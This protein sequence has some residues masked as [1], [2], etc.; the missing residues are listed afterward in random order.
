[1]STSEKQV[2]SITTLAETASDKHDS[3]RIVLVDDHQVVRQGV[4]AMLSIEK[5]MEIVGDYGSAEEAM[6]QIE[7]LSPDI[8]LLDFRM[9]GLNGIEACRLLKAKGLTCDV[10]ILTLY[11][12]HFAEA[13]R[14]GAKGYL[15]KDMKREELISTVRQVYHL[16]NSPEQD[17][18]SDSLDTIDL[19]I[20]SPVDTDQI[21]RFMGF[22]PVALQ[23]SIEQVIKLLDGSTAITMRFASSIKH[24]DVLDKLRKISDVKVVEKK[25]AAKPKFLW[26]FGGK[27]RSDISEKDQ[28]MITLGNNTDSEQ[29]N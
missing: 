3:I 10:V 7:E 8:V 14:A 25:L 24:K 2:L 21:V 6:P 18:A 9:P 20:L 28:I 26:P 23:G 11:K 22:A 16:K 29:E 19:V 17:N 5:D 15:P 13:M 27:L 4:R 1:M 12:E